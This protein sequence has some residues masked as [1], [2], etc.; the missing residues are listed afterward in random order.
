M[1]VFAFIDTNVLL[2]YR[3]FREVDWAA[4]LGES[5]VVLVLAPAVLSELDEHK[6]SGSRREKAR[7]KA[8]LKT[9]DEIELAA[10]TVGIRAGVGVMGIGHEPAEAASMTTGFSPPCWRFAKNAAL[11]I[12]CC[13]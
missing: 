7:A 12:K 5:E 8:V 1:Q 11:M 13:W 9:I 2:H 4:A 3:F 10:E 6:W